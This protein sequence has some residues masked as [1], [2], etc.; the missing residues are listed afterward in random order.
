MATTPPS[1][2]GPTKVSLEIIPTFSGPLSRS[3]GRMCFVM[4]GEA[5]G[6]G[7]GRISGTHIW[8]KERGG[9][10]HLGDQPHPCARSQGLEEPQYEEQTEPGGEPQPWNR[11]CG[12]TYERD[13]LERDEGPARTA[14]VRDRHQRQRTEYRREGGA[15]HAH[16]GQERGL[17]LLVDQRAEREARRGARGDRQCELAYRPTNS[18][19]RSR[20]R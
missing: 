15:V 2:A 6:C 14:S 12:N 1:D 10:H 17:G 8:E 3:P 19:L 9:W 18:R 13:A 5:S 4:G 16:S 7:E 11:L 20:S